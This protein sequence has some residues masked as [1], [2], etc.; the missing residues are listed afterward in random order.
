MKPDPARLPCSPGR[1][2]RPSPRLAPCPRH[3]AP[4]PAASRPPAHHERSAG[5]CDPIHRVMRTWNSGTIERLR[6]STSDVA[7]NASRGRRNS[8]NPP[9]SL[10]TKSSKVETSDSGGRKN[11]RMMSGLLAKTMRR[12]P[13]ARST[14]KTRNR[15]LHPPAAQVQQKKHGRR[16]QPPPPHVRYWAN[17]GVFA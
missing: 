8:T 17:H 14:E 5:R 12:P 1:G 10:R 11:T 2:R 3:H 13:T 4:C 16:Q 6:P 7:G 9:I 15:G